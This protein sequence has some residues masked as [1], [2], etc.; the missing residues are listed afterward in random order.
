MYWFYPRL[1]IDYLPKY[2]IKIVY[3]VTPAG[4]ANPMT[5]GLNLVVELTNGSG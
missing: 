1:L 2:F 3:Y 4:V 5:I